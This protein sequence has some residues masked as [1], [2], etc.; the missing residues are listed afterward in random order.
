MMTD[1]GKTLVLQIPILLQ[2]ILKTWARQAGYFDKAIVPEIQEKKYLDALMELFCMMAKHHEE[3]DEATFARVFRFFKDTGFTKRLNDEAAISK[4]YI[5]LD[6][7][8]PDM[9]KSECSCLTKKDPIELD[10]NCS[11][12]GSKISGNRSIAESE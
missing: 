5:K 6:R 1:P 4:R 9:I 2:D 3:M 11:L 12:H 7:T 10:P 8:E